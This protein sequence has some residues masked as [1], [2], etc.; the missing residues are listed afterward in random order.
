M[1][2]PTEAELEK[3][4][5]WIADPENV[6][7]CVELAQTAIAFRFDPSPWFHAC[8]TAQVDKAR[9]AMES[10]ANDN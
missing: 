1:P 2:K 7:A 9:K 3:L 4:D 8:I 6:D 5:A 10:D